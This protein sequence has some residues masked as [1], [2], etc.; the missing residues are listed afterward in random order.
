MAE[1]VSIPEDVAELKRSH[2]YLATV[3]EDGVGEGAGLLQQST[4]VGHRNRLF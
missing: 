4:V 2:R 3:R 1:A